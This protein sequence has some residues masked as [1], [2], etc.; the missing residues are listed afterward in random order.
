MKPRPAGGKGHGDRA[1]RAA[2]QPALRSAHTPASQLAPALAH[3][4]CIP[5]GIPGS[6]LGSERPSLAAEGVWSPTW[7]C[8]LRAPLPPSGP[9]GLTAP[10]THPHM[11]THTHS[12]QTLPALPPVLADA[13]LYMLGTSHPV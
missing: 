6:Q 7:S 8:S 4:L 10:Q 11:H 1:A 3:S 5:L 13:P 12:S 9:D 2:P